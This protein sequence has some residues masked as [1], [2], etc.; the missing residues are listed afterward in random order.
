MKIR[1]ACLAGT[2]PAILEGLLLYFAEPT[3]NNWVL[4]QSVLFWFSVGFLAYL[5]EISANKI[6]SSLL[7]TVLLNLP[8]YIALTVVANQPDHL[9]PLIVASLVMGTI[10][11]FVSMA[12][13]K[14][15]K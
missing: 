1:N 5:V 15:S 6:L 9:I 11:G 4:V 3:I 14:K 10:I 12:L 13:N 8:W 2:V 7:V